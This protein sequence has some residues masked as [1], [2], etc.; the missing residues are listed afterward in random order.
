M[1]LDDHIKPYPLNEKDTGQLISDVNPT[2]AAA[3]Y[4]KIEHLPEELRPYE[5][6]ERVG[7]NNLSDV[8]LLAILLRSGKKG[9][10]A[11][12][13]ARDLL[14]PRDAVGGL[15][16]LR[17]LSL[18]ELQTWGGVGPV[19]AG[20]IKACVE[21]GKR[22]HHPAPNKS[23]SFSSP[24][25][26][27]ELLSAELKFLPVEQVQILLL[28]VR[29]RL[30]RKV[31]VSQGGLSAAVIQPRDIFREAVRANAAAIV[32]VHNHPSGCCEASGADHESTRAVKQAGELMGIRLHDHVIIAKDGYYS[33]RAQ[34]S[35]WND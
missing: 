26:V 19:K 21:L 32:L 35:L 20:Q 25:T 28:D 16:R 18:E 33:M 4:R 13:L 2:P 30:I 29:N 34:T 12:D 15:S 31:I 5:K 8:E 23:A 24:E 17:D 6:M 27:N 14:F 11:L 9:K 3:D 10:N 1:P 22:L 7:E